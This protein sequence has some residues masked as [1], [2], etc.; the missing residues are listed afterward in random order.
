M[1]SL[2]A[3]IEIQAPIDRCFDI[4]R[5]I[6]AHED[7][8]TLISGRAVAGKTSTRSHQKNLRD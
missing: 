3:K 1:Q 8:S 2:H 7:T 5:S 4:V 6:K